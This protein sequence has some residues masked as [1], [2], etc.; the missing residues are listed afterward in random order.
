M[1]YRYKRLMMMTIIIIIIMTIS[2]FTDFSFHI[3]SLSSIVLDP[4]LQSLTYTSSSYSPIPVSQWFMV[5]LFLEIFPP[6]VGKSKY[7]HALPEKV[8]FSWVK[9]ST[10]E[11]IKPRMFQENRADNI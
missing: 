11:H 8:I 5:N 10:L 3:R 2:L 4:T 6:T 7:S 1:T 9:A